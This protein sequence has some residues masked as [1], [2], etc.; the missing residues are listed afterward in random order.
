[1][2][3]WKRRQMGAEQRAVYVKER[4]FAYDQ[5]VI[6]NQEEVFRIVSERVFQNR[7]PLWR[8]IYG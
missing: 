8:M 2:G 1:M 4:Q 5:A 3:E 7:F 6:I